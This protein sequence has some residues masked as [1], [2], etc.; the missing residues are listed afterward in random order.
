MLLS[1]S[2]IR[3]SY[4]SERDTEMPPEMVALA[5]LTRERHAVKQD[6]CALD[7]ITAQPMIDSVSR[8]NEERSR[9]N[10]Q[11]A[12]LMASIVE[13]FMFVRSNQVRNPRASS[14]SFIRCIV[15]CASHLTN[16]QQ[17]C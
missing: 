8:T 4:L 5:A 11:T 10:R 17:R 6:V 15:A 9:A 1:L 14:D 2:V 3:T 13:P 7:G 16:A 12:C